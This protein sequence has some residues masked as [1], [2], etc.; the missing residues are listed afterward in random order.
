M[1]LSWNSV[2]EVNWIRLTVCVVINVAYLLNIQAFTGAFARR[3][4]NR[5]YNTKFLNL[6]LFCSYVVCF[7]ILYPRTGWLIWYIIKQDDNKFQADKQ[8]LVI[9]SLVI[10]CFAQPDTQQNASYC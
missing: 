9:S 8:H 5:S 2:H 4:V 7:G 6:F 3:V 10:T 1:I